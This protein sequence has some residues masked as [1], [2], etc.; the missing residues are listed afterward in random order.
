MGK[1]ESD[2]PGTGPMKIRGPG[3]ARIVSTGRHSDYPAIENEVLDG[4][5]HHR[6]PIMLIILAVIAAVGLIMIVGSR[7]VNS[8]GEDPVGK[9][10]VAPVTIQGPGSAGASE[11]AHPPLEA[12][13]PKVTK[14]VTTPAETV[15]KTVPSPVPGPTVKIPVPG[16]TV[17]KTKGVPGPTETVTKTKEVP[18]PAKTV[19][20]T[21]EVPGP[22]E[23]VT[24]CFNI[25][26]VK[27]PCP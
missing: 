6:W 23:T 22:T 25:L 3:R 8:G 13:A 9:K 21:K 15:I 16:P 10:T 4:P 12:A 19:T 11:A 2:E 17:T 24:I 7:M 27:I 18:V 14:T 26:L 5:D 20:K 1:H